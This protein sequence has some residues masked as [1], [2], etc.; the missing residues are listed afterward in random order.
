[1]SNQMEGQDKCP[2]NRTRQ[3]SWETYTQNLQ[4]EGSNSVDPGYLHGNYFWGHKLLSGYNGI[5]LSLKKEWTL[6]TL[7][8]M[9]EPWRHYSNKVSQTQK[10]KCCIIPL[11][12][13]TL[14]SQK[15]RGSK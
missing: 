1:M 6:D 14:N 11:I 8:C 5:L 3:T 12:R 4:G 15:P 7:Y 2:N 13:C 10:G 9:K